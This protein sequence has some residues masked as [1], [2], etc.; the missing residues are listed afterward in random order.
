ML[1]TSLS[2]SR[3]FASAVDPQM[4]PVDEALPAAK[5]LLEAAHVPYRW[6]GGLAVV[7]HGYRRTTVDIDVLVSADALDRLR[8]LLGSYGF[9]EVRRGL[10]HLATGV[11]VDLLVEG[12]A[13]PREGAGL[14]PAPSDQAGCED[15]PEM[16]ALAPLIA[17]KLRA[18]RHQDLA[19]IVAL[20]KLLDDEAYLRVEAALDP[21]QRETLLL[22]RRD[23]LEELAWE[24]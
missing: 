23:A 2:R 5:A 14:Y 9:E 6:V 12:S 17:L 16:L 15:E 24:R 4:P 11:H 7:H 13:L 1:T 21:A 22:L 18:G 20:L 19:D 8:P 3:L 10:R